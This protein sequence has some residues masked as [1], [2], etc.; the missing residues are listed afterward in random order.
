M[1][2]I[3]FEKGK[4]PVV[5]SDSHVEVEETK[6]GTFYNLVDG[7]G[8][9]SATIQVMNNKIV[10]TFGSN[11]DLGK[12]LEIHSELGDFEIDNDSGEN[13]NKTLKTL[14]SDI[15]TIPW[16]KYTKKGEC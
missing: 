10:W 16:I 11:K 9:D 1:F 4:R 12:I 6:Q 5:K 3:I 15:D 14:V 13:K 7:L 2:E 8:G